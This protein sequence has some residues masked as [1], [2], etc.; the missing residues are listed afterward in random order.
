MLGGGGHPVVFSLQESHTK[1][2]R[3]PFNNAFRFLAQM[4]VELL[5]FSPGERLGAARG[6]RNYPPQTLQ[7]DHSLTRDPLF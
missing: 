2:G 3:H 5:S 4:Q 7:A 1:V 6:E